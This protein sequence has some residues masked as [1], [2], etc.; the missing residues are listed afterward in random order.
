MSVEKFQVGLK[1]IIGMIP[2]PVRPCGSCTLCCKLVPVQEGAALLEGDTVTASLPL[3]NKP[4]GQ[5]CE[6][7]D[8]SRG[9]KIYERRPKSCREWSCAWLCDPALPPQLEPRRCHVVIDCVSDNIRVT[10][11]DGTAQVRPVVQ[12]W[13]DPA[14][15]R[16]WRAPVVAAAM[17]YYAKRFGFVTLVRFN[18]ER[19]IVVAPPEISAS[20]R[21]EEVE[22]N[23][24]ID[25]QEFQNQIADL[26]GPTDV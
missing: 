14:Y 20:G 11:P 16:A 1:D 8:K 22:S 26:K 2:Q 15:P 6:H 24:A 10:L 9:C 17:S 19:G 7:C 4:A 23:V 5:W 25:R 13:C 12:M 18:Q 3:F 21:W